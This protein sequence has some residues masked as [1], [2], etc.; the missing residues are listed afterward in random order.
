MRLSRR[1]KKVYDV[2]HDISGYHN[3]DVYKNHN[4]TELLAFLSSVT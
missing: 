2:I 3:N 4:P 1:E